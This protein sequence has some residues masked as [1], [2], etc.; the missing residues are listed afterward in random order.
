MRKRIY[1][2]DYFVDEGE[3]PVVCA[4]PGCGEEGLYPAPVSVSSIAEYNLFCMDH[5]RERNK[6]WN[7]FD[8]MNSVQFRAFE[9]DAECGHRP[10]RHMHSNSYYYYA[11]LH[12]QLNDLMGD[13]VSQAIHAPMYQQ[14]FSAEEKAAVET[15]GLSHPVMLDALK[16]RYKELVKRYHPDANNGKDVCDE[17]FRDIVEA[18]KLL[19]KSQIL[20]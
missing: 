1:D 2:Y 5:V 4:C 10:T 3:K 15:L 17:L 19:A 6:Q 13:T 18:Y 20:T 16:K 14:A 12:S 7:Y 8:G 11:Q 9:K